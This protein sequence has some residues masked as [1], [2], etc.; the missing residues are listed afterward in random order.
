M[1]MNYPCLYLKPGREK[2]LLHGHPWLFSGAVASV[3]GKP[4]PGDIVAVADAGGRSLGLGFFNSRSDIIFRFLTAD[5]DTRCDA[6]FWR[7]R[8][9][10]AEALRRRILPPDTTACRLINAEGD[11][12]PGLIV[13]RYDDVLVC[14]IAT[15]GMEKNRTAVLDALTGVC[16]P[17]G[18]Y[19]R[20]EGRARRLEGLEERSGWIYG[21]CEEGKRIPVRE[22][23]LYFEVD[24]VGGQ[25]TGFFLDQRSNREGVAGLSRGMTLLNCF[26]YSGAFSVYAARGGAERVVSVDV[27]EGANDMA[28]FHLKKN[29]FSTERHPV[30]RADVFSWLRETEEVFDGII[31]DPP[32]FAKSR[33]D[34]ARS[35]RGYKDINLQAIKHLQ[36]GGLLW[37]FSC[38]SFMDEALFQKVVL[39]AACDT[40]KSVQLLKILGPGPDHPTSLAHMEG[41]YLKGLLLRVSDR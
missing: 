19:E 10:F 25:K 12:L 23:G 27:S 2:A 24:I 40:G 30:I 16:S 36:N 17:R 1:K 33:K 28:R 6:H 29:G 8:V 21:S 39:G 5:V 26:S 31:L 35:A 4:A 13:D 15:A 14:S 7:E 38:S 18:I 3:E 41:R 20:S 9:R 34:I 22:N 37:T 11:G 32:A